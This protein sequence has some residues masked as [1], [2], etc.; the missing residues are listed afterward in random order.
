[1][2]YTLGGSP[3]RFRG[4]KRAVGGLGILSPIYNRVR[5]GSNPR[6]RTY[7]VGNKVYDGGWTTTD[8]RNKE[9]EMKI[10]SYNIGGSN[11]PEIIKYLGIGGALGAI[12]FSYLSPTVDLQKANICF[13]VG[14]LAI[15]TYFYCKLQDA[16]AK[17]ETLED[18]NRFNHERDSV[19]RRFDDIWSQVS[20]IDERIDRIEAN[21]G[22]PKNCNPK[23]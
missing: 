10:S 23:I 2:L 18:E 11:F 15:A 7:F 9:F 12:W 5:L 6:R 14:I 17:N 19:D 13:I 8:L 1:M 22:S 3:F 20:K 21:C 16:V 4:Y